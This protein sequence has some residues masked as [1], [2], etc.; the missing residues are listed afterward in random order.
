MNPPE[1]F[2]IEG[3]REQITDMLAAVQHPGYVRADDHALLRLELDACHQEI[4]RLRF[5]L[6]Q[7]AD[8]L[9]KADEQ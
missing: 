9:T 7:V 4:T 3:A 2:G 1:P 8:A 5:V 6:G